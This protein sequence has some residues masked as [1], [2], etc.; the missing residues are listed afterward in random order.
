MLVGFDG[1]VDWGSRTA[2]IY[3]KQGNGD[4][5]ESMDPELGTQEM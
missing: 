5:E 4:L 2:H 1:R 3:F